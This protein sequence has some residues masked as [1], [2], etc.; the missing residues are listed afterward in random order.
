MDSDP[1]ASFASTSPDQTAALGRRLALSLRPGDTI[2]LGGRLGAGKTLFA[3]AV[4]GALTGEAE[5]PSPTYTLVQTYAGP[6]C[7]VWHAD[8]Y[9]LAD[10]VEVVELGLSDAFE[11]AIA[12]VEWPDRLDPPPLG[13][14][15]LAFEPGEE[16][17]TRR[18]IARGPASR[19]FEPVTRAFDAV[20][21]DV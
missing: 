4:I 2:C 10:P 6:D 15:W 17:D 12:L 1:L 21:A 19:W 16:T 3:R 7:E 14:L 8:L 9:R 18:I 20:G 11:T 5:V 13:A